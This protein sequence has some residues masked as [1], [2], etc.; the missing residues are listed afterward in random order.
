VYPIFMRIDR[1]VNSQLM[2]H[3]RTVEFS[4]FPGRL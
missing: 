4:A 1:A 3:V 2:S